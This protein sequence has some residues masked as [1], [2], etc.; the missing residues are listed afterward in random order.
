[1]PTRAGADGAGPHA[2]PPPRL[3]RRGEAVVTAVALASGVAAALSGARPTP[4]VLASLL[5][6]ALLGFAV[7]GAAA[8]ADRWLLLLP[9]AVGAMFGAPGTWPLIAL[10]VVAT[11]VAVAVRPGSAPWAALAGALG[12]QVLL[13]LAP[14]GF[15]G[16][17]SLLAGAALAPVLWSGWRA[18]STGRADRAAPSRRARRVR[19]GALV[20]GLAAATVVAGTAALA[21]WFLLRAADEADAGLAAVRQGDDAPAHGHLDRAEDGFATA[22]RL[23]SGWWAAPLRAVPVVAHHVRAA[24]VVAREG[25]DVSVAATE[26]LEHAD[27][28]RLRAE[29]GRFDTARIEAMAAPLRR[30]E[31]TVAAARDDVAPVRSPWLL[32]PFTGA[33]DRLDDALARADHDLG[34]VRAGVSVAPGLLGAEGPRRY[35]VVFVTPAETRGSGGFIGSYAEL[36]ADG[37]ELDLVRTGSAGS[38]EQRAPEGVTVTGPPDYLRRYGQHQPERYFRDLTFSPHFPDDAEVISQVYSQ[39]GGV[40]VDGVISVDPIALASLLRLTGPVFVE[41]F[42]RTL[43]A[44][45]AA[46]FLLS[47]NYWLF[48][49]DA[50]QNAALTELVETVFDRLTTGELPTPAAIGEAV[51]GP[52]RSGRIRLWSPRAEEQAFFERLGVT[53]AFPPP[54]DDHDFLA[55]ASQNAGHNK[56]DV[57]QEREVDYRVDL[58]DDGALTATVR[59]VVRNTLPPGA[60]VPDYIDGNSRGDP[61]GANRMMVS[62]YSPHE[63]EGARVD[64][65]TVGMATDHEAG[66]QVYSRL[67]IVP[68]GQELTL[69]L[70]LRGS[71]APGGAYRLDHVAQ[72]MVLPQALRVDLH[73]PGRDDATIGPLPPDGRETLVI[74]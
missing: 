24:D 67:L 9:A 12:V 68:A 15:H 20:V 74:P 61:I 70:D 43:D 38:L 66:Y 52:A 36:V 2:S 16:L 23:L 48:P 55:V 34:T 27:H 47:D 32:A 8:A 18:R 37:G 49:D 35:V 65:T 71:L 72:P 33:L 5:L 28:R 57:Y 7:T 21:G 6:S 59:V 11:V 17:P 69:E 64:G 25:R 50:A 29:D 63:L 45:N 1:M 58:D 44:D 53:G 3:D 39:I 42:G 30:A 51:S 22:H 60:D 14:V 26:V 54:R 62:V 40:D 73:R 19:R 10:A 4:G 31:A 13:R 41:G 46:S 56:L